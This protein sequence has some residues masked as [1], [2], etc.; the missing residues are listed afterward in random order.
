MIEIVHYMNKYGK[1]MVAVFPGLETLGWLAKAPPQA[2][3]YTHR[4]HAGLEKPAFPLPAIHLE[5]V[6]LGDDYMHDTVYLH[7]GDV[8]HALWDFNYDRC[9]D[10]NLPY[11]EYQWWETPMVP[12]P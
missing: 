7:D 1:K 5:A 10:F 11:G 3:T 9:Q 12:V 2:A 4:Y 8:I 6:F